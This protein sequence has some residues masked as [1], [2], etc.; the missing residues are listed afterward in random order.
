[1]LVAGL[2]RASAMVLHT[3]GRRVCTLSR[4][5]HRRLLLLSA[6]ERAAMAPSTAKELCI[7]VPSADGEHVR[8]LQI[9]VVSGSTA[10]ATTAFENHCPHAGGPLNMLPDR[11]FSRDGFLMCTRHGAKFR[12]DD[13]ECVH[14]PCPDTALN[15]LPI[16]DCPHDGVLTTASALHTLCMDGGGAYVLRPRAEA[17]GDGNLQVLRVAHVAPL[18]RRPRRRA[19]VDTS[20]DR[21]N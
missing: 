4:G 9:F 1:M 3:F 7:Q 5:D 19:S 8:H 17:T 2:S 11:F 15:A 13:G 16:I 18:P 20:T 6:A 12:W 10:G 21:S 14:G